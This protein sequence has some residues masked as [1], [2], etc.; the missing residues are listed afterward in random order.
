M[1]LRKW[2]TNST[3]FR[4]TIPQDLIETADLQLP[5]QAPLASSKALGMHWDVQHDTL[6]IA[7]PEAEDFSITKRLVASRAAKIYDIMD[8]FTPATITAKLILQEAWKCQTSWDEPLPESLA[9]RWK[10]WTAELSYISNR[11]VPRCLLTNKDSITFISMHDFADASQSAYGA[12]IY[13]R[14]V[15]RD[16]SVSTALVLSRARVTPIKTTT[17]PRLKLSAALL[18]ARAISYVANLLKCPSSQLFLWSDS[19]IVLC[20]LKK[21]LSSMNTFVS[22]RVSIIQKTVPDSTWRYVP[23]KDNPADLLSRG[24]RPS[25]LTNTDLWWNGPPWLQSSPSEWPSQPQLI[26]KSLPEL[27]AQVLLIP[28]TRPDKFWDRY[29]LFTYLVS[30][31]AW[32]R[33][34]FHNVKHLRSERISEPVLTS[35]E[36]LSSKL[37]LF[38]LSQREVYPEVFDALVVGKNLPILSQRMM[39][40]WMLIVF[41]ESM[42]EY[43]SERTSINHNLE[44]PFPL[45]LILPVSSL[46]P[47][48]LLT[49][50]LVFLP[51]CVY[52]QVISIFQD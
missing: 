25:T 41:S 3:S 34:F 49:L 42:A 19:Q 50:I 4:D 29:S 10:Q 21:S 17:I 12:V 35:A 26:P 43:A 16:T 31:V 14:V 36:T 7:T 24:V 22:N 9:E 48:I 39:F 40:P 18:L 32:I 6:H 30:V 27:R 1:T 8:L 47:S 33:R 5:A 15:H 37:Q 23:S 45:N 13:L 11:P 20:W 44:S 28:S 38:R 2:R 51:C 46:L 52:L